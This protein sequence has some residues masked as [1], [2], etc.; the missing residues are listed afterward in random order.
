MTVVSTA[1][2]P[3]LFPG[4]GNYSAIRAVRVLRALRTVNRIPSLKKI[5]NSLL[6]AIPDLAN[7]AVLFLFFV[8]LFGIAGVTLFQGGLHRRCTEKGSDEFVD[9]VAICATDADCDAGQTC[10]FYDVNPANGALSYDNCLWAFV[11]IFQAVSLEGWVDQ[12]YMLSIT[13]VPWL[14]AAYYVALVVIGAMFITN[15]FLAV[16][17]DAFLKSNDD[18]DES[19]STRRDGQVERRTPTCSST[20]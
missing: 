9:D 20:S 16:I 3:L 10:E 14:T 2:A 11:T 5:I 1:W 17:F 4:V 6:S 8:F 19:G 7:V 13:S 12:M 18:M 15:L